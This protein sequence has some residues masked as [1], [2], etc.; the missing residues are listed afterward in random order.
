VAVEVARRIL[1]RSVIGVGRRLDDDRTTRTR[2]GVMR[3]DVVDAD[4]YALSDRRPRVVV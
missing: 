2:A 3:V 4:V 1:A